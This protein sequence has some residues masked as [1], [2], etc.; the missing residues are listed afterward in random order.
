[1]KTIYRNIPA[2]SPLSKR[3]VEI[4]HF[5]EEGKTTTQI[6]NGLYI[7]ENTVKTH[8]HHIMNKLDVSSR[9]DAVRRAYEL[10]ILNRRDV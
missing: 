3:E 4:L 2:S 10:G 6:A 7:S 9:R 5:L 8:V 1:M